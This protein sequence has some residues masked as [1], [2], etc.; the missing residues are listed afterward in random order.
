M[1]A[2][3][4][5][6]LDPNSGLY[7]SEKQSKD[8]ATGAPVRLVTWFDPKTGVSKQQSYPVAQPAPTQPKVSEPA[9]APVTTPTVPTPAASPTTP[10]APAPAAPA[11]PKGPA[12]IP[13]GFVLDPQS[14]LYYRSEK[15][16]DAN[17]ALI[18][19][20][21]YYDPAKK[22]YHPVDYPAAQTPA[23]QGAQPLPAPPEPPPTFSGHSATL[24]QESYQPIAK[25]KALMPIVIAGAAVLLVA[26]LGI[27]AWQFGWF[28][29]SASPSGGAPSSGQ[30]QKAG[31]RAESIAET[32]ESTDSTT[33]E[34]I[35]ITFP[36]SK[37]FE[38]TY[39]FE[40]KTHTVKG[41]YTWDEN[42]IST[43]SKDSAPGWPGSCEWKRQSNG[44]ALLGP[45]GIGDFALYRVLTPEN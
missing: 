34:V 38:L 31:E 9:V 33:G 20:V 15:G 43:T 29:K 6:K 26:V 10:I 22:T 17:G 42:G 32:Y 21:T 3:S 14:K 41:T 28:S 39:D 45:S 36:D 1:D 11:P 13:D 30:T 35:R 27:C 4:G 25:K 37:N 16:V 44:I 23:T 7:Y 8:S 18:Q 19:R 12:P 24:R 40:G 5:F 2:P